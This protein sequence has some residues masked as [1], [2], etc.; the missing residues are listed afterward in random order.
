[1]IYGN[2]WHVYIRNQTI[3]SAYSMVAP[4]IRLP[5][6]S[7]FS[8]CTIIC[9]CY[10]FPSLMSSF[11]LH[12]KD[13]GSCIPVD[14]NELENLKVNRNKWVHLHIIISLNNTAMC[15]PAP[16]LDCSVFSWPPSPYLIYVL[17]FEWAF[18]IICQSKGISKHFDIVVL[19]CVVHTECKCLGLGM[20]G[21]GYPASPFIILPASYQRR[22]L[23]W[24][25]PSIMTG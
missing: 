10:S 7:L 21:G 9:N 6:R 15:I 18:P 5:A 19:R 23:L 24:R 25:Q 14:F 4:Q 13:N 1:M 8:A 17:L 16:L 11:H 3:Y 12:L 20:I 2:A 22:T